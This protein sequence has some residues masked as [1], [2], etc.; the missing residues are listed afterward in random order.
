MPPS[1]GYELQQPDHPLPL[2]EN[3]RGQTGGVRPRASGDAVLDPDAGLLCHGSIQSRR[4]RSTSISLDVCLGARATDI[5]PELMAHTRV[6]P[7]IT[8]AR[9]A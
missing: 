5:L 1:A 4:Q 2:F 9:G 3:P 6:A 7:L 8:L